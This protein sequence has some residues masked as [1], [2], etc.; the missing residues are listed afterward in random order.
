MDIRRAEHWLERHGRAVDQATIAYV[1]SG[2]IE[3]LYDALTPYANKDGGFGHALEPDVR[4]ADSSILATTV[5]LQLLAMCGATCDNNL[6]ANAMSYL[7]GTMQS[8]VD[9]W[10]IVPENVG[11]AAHAPW[12]KFKDIDGNMINP[13][14]EIVGYMYRW[15]GFFDSSLVDKITRDIDGYMTNAEQLEIHDLLCLDRMLLSPGYPTQ[16]LASQSSKFYE[17]AKQMV[18]TDAAEWDHYGLTPLTVVRTPDHPLAP[19]LRLAIGENFRYL[20]TKQD[21]DGSWAP[22]WSWYGNYEDEWKIAEIEIR[23]KIVADN[24]CLAHHFG[25]RA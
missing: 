8:D 16:L 20:A 9:A 17:L 19:V 24:L 11:D 12:W 3:P 22:S 23:S 7:A 18:S 2:E 13:R 10:Q 6:V 15:P 1:I 14:A 21:G 4:L 5:A 25:K